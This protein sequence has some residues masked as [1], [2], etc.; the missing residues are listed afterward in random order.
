MRAE[1]H[2]AKAA[3]LET[4]RN[5]LSV[6]QDYEI[7]IWTCIHAGAHLLNASLH[8]L[9]FSEDTRDYIHSHKVEPDREIPGNV[10]ELL[11]VLKSIE[12][13]G[14]R[15]VRGGERLDPEA[16]V[17]AC[18]TSYAKLKGSAEKLVNS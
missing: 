16:A 9:G 7:I 6:E 18:L 14:P 12:L 4:S 15:F 2:W 17:K 3:R 1:E 8:K 5:K 10:A 11:S 13:L